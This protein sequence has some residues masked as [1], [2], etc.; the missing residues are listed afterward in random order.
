M[1]ILVGRYAGPHRCPLIEKLLKGTI[2][3][4]PICEKKNVG[5]KNTEKK[6]YAKGN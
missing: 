6:E 2:T 1:A 5:K 4:K 3:R